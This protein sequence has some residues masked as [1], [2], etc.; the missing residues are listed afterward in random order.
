[1]AP[2]VPPPEELTFEE[3][4]QACEGIVAPLR[5]LTD[6][7][8]LSVRAENLHYLPTTKLEMSARV[9]WGGEPFAWLSPPS[10]KGGKWWVHA[11]GV[12]TDIEANNL[13]LA[14]VSV[15]LMQRLKAHILWIQ[16]RE[17]YMR[18]ANQVLA[19]LAEQ[20][21]EAATLARD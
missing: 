17:V 8:G 11:V 3:F 4:R 15:V 10:A 14:E 20:L 21:S 12:P 18:S 19:S 2:I 9:Y 7:T 16:G 6:Q 5:A 1:M 13:S